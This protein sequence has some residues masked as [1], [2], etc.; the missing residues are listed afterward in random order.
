[1]VVLGICEGESG[2][3]TGVWLTTQVFQ[4]QVEFV[5][6]LECIV[7]T[8]N[9]R[10]L[11]RRE[12]ERHGLKDL[13]SKGSEC[14]LVRKWNLVPCTFAALLLARATPSCVRCGR[15]TRWRRVAPKTTIRCKLACK[16]CW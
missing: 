4:D 11:Q 13:P 7:E 10:M 14:V 6:C 12:R 5:V 1:M 9:G 15:T 16:N 2:V 8:D 3:I